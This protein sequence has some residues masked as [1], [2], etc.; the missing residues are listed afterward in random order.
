MKHQKFHTFGWIPDIP[1]QRDFLYTAVRPRVK[2]S[3]TV[4]LREKCSMIEDQGKLGSCTAQALAGNIEFLD[5]LPDTQYTDVSRLFIYYN[6]R[7]L[8]HYENY[9]SGASL[10]DGIR[11]LKHQGVCDESLWPYK[12]GDFAKKP[13]QKCYDNAK[14]HCIKTYYRIRNLNE[15]L[16]CLS[17]GY[18]F[19]FGFTVYESFLTEKV[20]QTGIA[21][22]PGNSERAQGGH[23]VMAVGYDQKAKRFLIRNSWG[24]SWGIEGHFTIPFEYLETLAADFWTIRK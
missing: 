12:V 13:S 4:D 6:E 18:P 7:V 23:A 8:I 9:D 2:L 16:A 14:N 5:N 22:M 10:R 3:K 15:M 17:D 1:D 20:A 21:S 11:T 19:V 24:T